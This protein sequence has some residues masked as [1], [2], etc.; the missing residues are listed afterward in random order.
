MPPIIYN[1]NDA[2]FREKMM[3]LDFDWTMVTP[4]D[5]K[6]FPEDVNDWRWFNSTVPHTIKRHYDDG[7]MIVIFTNQSKEW[8]Y[9]QIRT[10][11]LELG[12]PV[13]VVIAT[14]RDEYKPNLVIFDTL[15]ESNFERNQ[16]DKSKSFFVGDALGRK[17]DFADSDKVFA[18]N[19][20]ISW[21]SP[22]QMFI[23]TNNNDNKPVFP[24]S[25]QLSH[26]ETNEPEIIIMV[27]YPGSGKS[28][29]AKEIC[30]NNNYSCVPGDI[31]KSSSKMIKKSL[32]YISQGKSVVFD[33]TN[34]SIVKRRDYILHGQK[35]NYKIKCVHV[36]TSLDV[37]YERNKMREES[38][39]IPRI[40]YAVYKKY[41]DP[42]TESEGFALITV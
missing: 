31:Y 33:A 17:N 1:L 19:I 21:M 30:K 39:Q 36:S 35:F 13:F 11:A 3:A 41:Y 26:S 40:A 12:I 29:I 34:S 9:K 32:E 20:G 18:E 14:D 6:T 27:G 2:S 15:V 24:T 38:A 42:P 16:I 5:G 22:E 10:V 37:S 28:T 23:S 25:I 4:K 8:K 7:Y